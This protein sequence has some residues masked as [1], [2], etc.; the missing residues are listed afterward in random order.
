[1]TAASTELD[2]VWLLR[3]RIFIAWFD[4]MGLAQWWSTK[5]QFGRLGVATLPWDFPRTHHFAQSCSMFALAT[6]RCTEVFEPTDRVTLWRL[7]TTG[8]TSQC[9]SGLR[10]WSSRAPRTGASPSRRCSTMCSGSRNPKAVDRTH[11]THAQ[12][13]QASAQTDPAVKSARK[14]L[15]QAPDALGAAKKTRKESQCLSPFT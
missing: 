3:L 8:L 14:R 1:V 9:R 4:E 13:R 6:H 15:L 10:A 2:L 11:A 12:R 7:S 5:G